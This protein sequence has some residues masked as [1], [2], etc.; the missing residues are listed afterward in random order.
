MIRRLLQRIS[1]WFFRKTFK[2]K[3]SSKAEYKNSKTDEGKKLE[4]GSI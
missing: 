1:V 2:L 3:D 4:N